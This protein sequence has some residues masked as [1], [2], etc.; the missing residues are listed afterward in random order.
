MNTRRS[1]MAFANYGG[2][3]FVAGGRGADGEA[4]C[5]CE[6][7]DG[8]AWTAL[9]DMG[10]ARLGA[11]LVATEGGLLVVGGAVDESSREADGFPFT[12]P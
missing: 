5:S 12:V 10:V 11:A 7:F 2:R 1:A 8:E 6:S 4:L 3:L 9:P